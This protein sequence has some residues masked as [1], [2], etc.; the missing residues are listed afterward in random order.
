MIY[1]S[2]KLLVSQY[3]TKINYYKLKYRTHGETYVWSCPS[4][5]RPSEPAYE[6]YGLLFCMKTVAKLIIVVR[7]WGLVGLCKLINTELLHQQ[8]SS[9]NALLVRPYC[10]AYKIRA[11]DWAQVMTTYFQ[12]SPKTKRDKYIQYKHTCF[13]FKQCEIKGLKKGTSIEIRCKKGERRG[14]GGEERGV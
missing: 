9:Q 5:C 13:F 12:P 14:G 8:N 6:T 2:K 4:V 11:R 10:I 1:I 7:V 3:Q